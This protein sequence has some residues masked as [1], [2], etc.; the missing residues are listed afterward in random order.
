MK[1]KKGFTLIELLVVIAI[2]ALLLSIVMP[3]LTRA[4]LYA[5]RVM[6]SNNLRQQTLGTLLYSNDNDSSV[7][8]SAGGYWLWDMSFLSTNLMSQFAG[9]D[10]NKTFFCP[11]N[12]MKKADDARFWQYRWLEVQNLGEDY[13]QPVPLRD[14]R[15]LTLSQLRDYYRVLP[16]VYMFD[17]F[18]ADGTSKLPDRLITGEQARWITKL[19]SLPA[20]SARIMI[21]DAVISEGNAWNF[22]D[23]DSGGIDELSGGTLY[24]STNHQSRQTIRAAGGSG[25]KPAGGNIAYADGHVDWRRFD[26]MEHR[27][28]T[29]GMWFWW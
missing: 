13:T 14:E 27:I 11:A 22:F 9:F 15:N 2:I 20:A 5:Q 3:A 21:M 12:K 24:D 1:H 28:T 7:P 26:I 25:P 6:C 23:I 16:M 17:K 8:R 4:K 29:E 18:N 10:D 19:S